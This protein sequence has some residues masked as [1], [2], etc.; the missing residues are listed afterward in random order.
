M[1]HK[2]P[3][4]FGKANHCAG[5]RTAIP[6]HSAAVPKTHYLGLDVRLRR[7]S[8][9]ANRLD[10][11]ADRTTHDY[12]RRLHNCAHAHYVPTGVDIDGK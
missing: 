1:T 7:R 12:L 6:A 9:S 5:S 3:G 4:S 11:P 8:W 10:T 2:S